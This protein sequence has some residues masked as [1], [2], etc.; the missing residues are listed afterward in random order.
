VGFVQRAS[1]W[2]A[3]EWCRRPERI[4]DVEAREPRGQ[5]VELL[6]GERPG[7]EQRER[8][9][10]VGQTAH[11]DAML[12]RVGRERLCGRSDVRMRTRA[13]QRGHAEIDVRREPPVERDLAQAVGVALRA[14]GEAHES[15]V[16]RLA[17]LVDAV[18][19][20]VDVG[21]M[22]LNPLDA[23]GRRSIAR[24]RLCAR[25]LRPVRGHFA[26]RRR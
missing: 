12:A 4:R 1:Q 25:E 23:G 21:E 19:G 3:R 20:P 8:I 15:Q 2:L 6:R 11:H 24:K 26:R 5:R 7:R 9:A 16:D 18:G 14:R 10:T 17:E 13:E 22:G